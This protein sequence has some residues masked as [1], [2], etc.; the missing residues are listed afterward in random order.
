MPLQIPWM[1]TRTSSSPLSLLLPMC[2]HY[3]EPPFPTL[4][5]SNGLDS[6]SKKFFLVLCSIGLR[7]VAGVPIISVALAK[8]SPWQCTFTPDPISLWGS[9]P[10]DQL[11]SLWMSFAQR[12]PFPILPNCFDSS[13]VSWNPSLCPNCPCC[14][15]HPSSDC[16]TNK[17]CFFLL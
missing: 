14:C 12:L 15:N 3:C 7:P 11:S 6:V 4:L 2:S 1:A 10:Q 16:E 9:A 5:S 8:P 17:V 13:K